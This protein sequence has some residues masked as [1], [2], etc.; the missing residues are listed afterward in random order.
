MRNDLFSVY[1]LLKLLFEFW[2][3]FR[4]FSEKTM[5]IASAPM[6]MPN[7]SREGGEDFF[8]EVADDGE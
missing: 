3:C 1:A 7:E 2:S 4:Y 8:D 6:M 5:E